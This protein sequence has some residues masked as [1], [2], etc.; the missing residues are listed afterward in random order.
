MGSVWFNGSVNLFRFAPIQSKTGHFQH[1]QAHFP[2]KLICVSTHLLHWS[3]R[4]HPVIR[5]HFCGVALAEASQR[6]RDSV[7]GDGVNSQFQLCSIRNW[8]WSG[9]WFVLIVLCTFTDRDPLTSCWGR[10]GRKLRTQPLLRRLWGD[11][12][13]SFTYSV[14]ISSWTANDVWKHQDKRV[15]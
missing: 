9:T 14:T 13:I 10:S 1:Q 2:M 11:K 8:Q 7:H 5:E 3:H 6:R 4:F 15:P 12:S